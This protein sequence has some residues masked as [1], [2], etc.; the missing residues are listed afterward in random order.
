MIK[1]ILT[2]LSMFP[3][4]CFS[5]EEMRV[6]TGTVKDKQ[7]T[8]ALAFATIMIQG[9]ST[10]TTADENGYF[11]LELPT[12]QESNVLLAIFSGYAS[13]SLLIS[14]EKQ[15]YNFNLNPETGVFGEVVIS[16]TMSEVSKLESPIPV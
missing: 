8:E 13:D 14:S 6:I 10:G 1:A 3:L 9:T 7:S 11:K 12:V 5:G 15:V 2:T 16:G 4:L